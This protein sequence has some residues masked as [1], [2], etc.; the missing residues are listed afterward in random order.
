MATTVPARAAKSTQLYR[1]AKP[2]HLRPFGLRRRT[3]WSVRAS[4]S[5]TT[6]SLLAISRT[7]SRR[8]TGWRPRRRCGWA[9]EGWVANTDLRGAEWFV[10]F[11]MCLLALQKRRDV[12][13]FTNGFLDYDLLAR[14]VVH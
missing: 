4:R 6:C 3:C 8:S 11:F 14:R 13:G 2:T 7:P 10:A 9:N 1:M 5:T 12:E